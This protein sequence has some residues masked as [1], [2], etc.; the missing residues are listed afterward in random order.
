MEVPV[1]VDTVSVSDDALFA[2][3]MLIFLA[4]IFTAT[5]IIFYS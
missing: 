1:C 2:S 3:E 5:A 4:E